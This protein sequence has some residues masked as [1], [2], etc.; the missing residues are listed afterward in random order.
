MRRLFKCR[1]LQFSLF[2][3]ELQLRCINKCSIFAHCWKL[4]IKV[5]SIK[6]SL[7]RIPSQKKYIIF[8][9]LI[10]KVLPFLTNIFLIKIV[11]LRWNE[12]RLNLPIIQILPRIILQPRMIL[13]FLWTIQ[14]QSIHRLS[15]YHFISKIRCFNAPT[16]RYLISSNLYLFRK[17]MVSNF[18]P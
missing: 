9:L 8:K 17:D 13:Y 15:L 11:L 7:N 5:V 14:P 16:S 18:F 2:F 10:F 3:L 1:S 4:I 6:E 12:P